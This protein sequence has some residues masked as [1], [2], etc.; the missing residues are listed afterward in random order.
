MYSP[1]GNDDWKH[2]LEMLN[3]I[4]TEV[5][6]YLIGHSFGAEACIR[7][8][9]ILASQNRRVAYLGLIDPVGW[10]WNDLTLPNN[11]DKYDWFR[12]SWGFDFSFTKRADVKGATATIISGTHNSL[13]HKVEVITKIVESI[14]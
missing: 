9:N 3:A 4:G 1:S 6:I 11:V 14:K 7:V 5:V 8:A 13:P 12:R 2:T 10:K